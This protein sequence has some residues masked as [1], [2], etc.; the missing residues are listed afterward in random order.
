MPYMSLAS[1][2]A[3]TSAARTYSECG[4][5]VRVLVAADAEADL[6]SHLHRH[7]WS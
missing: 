1:S 3:H 5:V 4:V 7:L 2:F 6:V